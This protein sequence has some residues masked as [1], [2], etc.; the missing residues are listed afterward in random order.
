MRPVA[1][2][3]SRPRSTSTSSSRATSV[4]SS[5]YQDAS[6]SAVTA[7][8]GA[9]TAGGGSERTLTRK[10]WV[11]A[12]MRPS[13]RSDDPSAT[14]RHRRYVAPG[15]ASPRAGDE[16]R[17]PRDYKQGVPTAG[18]RSVSKDNGR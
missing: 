7:G 5:A 12:R 18:G 17:Q 15:V 11:R 2:D 6:S 14:E 8:V 9:S 10:L 1:S 13:P 3:A 16:H 4:P